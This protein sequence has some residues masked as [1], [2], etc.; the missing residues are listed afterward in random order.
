MTSLA[1]RIILRTMGA[2]LMLMAVKV[3][4]LMATLLLNELVDLF[5]K[6]I[7]GGGPIR[8]LPG[9]R[10]TKNGTHSSLLV[11]EPSFTIT[12]NKLTK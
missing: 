12:N 10:S 1:L 6:G 8:I 4:I 2:S 11:S 5:E 7:L 3:V 9:Q